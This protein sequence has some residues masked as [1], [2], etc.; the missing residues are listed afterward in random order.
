MIFVYFICVFFVFV[1]YK[2]CAKAF[3]NLTTN[4]A[5]TALSTTAMGG[6]GTN[7]IHVK[8]IHEMCTLHLNFFFILAISDY[9]SSQHDDFIRY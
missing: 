8:I 6:E 7:T 9:G 2:I 5:T 1:S 4:T 3:E